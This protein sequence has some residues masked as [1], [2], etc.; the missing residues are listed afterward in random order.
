[1]GDFLTSG[2]SRLGLRLGT[3]TQGIYGEERSNLINIE[4]EFF[5]LKH[6]FFVCAKPEIFFFF[7]LTGL[8]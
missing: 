4:S 3:S 5:F 1:M 6:T 8:V 7:I 2:A